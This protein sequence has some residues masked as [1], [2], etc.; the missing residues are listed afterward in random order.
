MSVQ[1]SYLFV[2]SKDLEI[3]RKA[4]HSRSDTVI[5]DLEDAVAQTKKNQ[6]RELMIKA[7]LE[8]KGEKSIYVRIND[9][10]TAYWEQDLNASIRS[11]AKGVIVPK[12]EDKEEIRL[13]CEKVRAVFEDIG[14]KP[15]ERNFEVI[16]LLETAKGIQFVYEIASSDQLISR[17]AFGSIDFSLDVGCELTEGGEELLYARSKIVIASKAAKKGG[18]IDAV[19]PNLDH[20]AGLLQETRSAKQL[21]F[22]GKLI[23]HPKQ[24]EA[25]HEVFTL[26]EEQLREAKEI[27]VAFEQAERQGFASISLHHKLIDYPVYKNA[28]QILAESGF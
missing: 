24:I 1:R 17:L 15:Q 8:L 23:I 21:G 6:A 28:K 3:I 16:P 18:P 27:I 9:M 26:T 4:V 22:K 2:P 12:S 25:V 5:I 11:G 20:Q 14:Q 10:S 7:L 13:L 19:Y